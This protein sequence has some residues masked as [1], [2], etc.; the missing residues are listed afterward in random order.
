M[1]LDN[2]G[3]AALSLALQFY[4]CPGGATGHADADPVQENP[5]GAAEHALVPVQVQENPAGAAE[6]AVVPVLLQ[7]GMLNDWLLHPE[8]LDARVALSKCMEQMRLNQMW[9][10]ELEQ[11][12]IYTSCILS[13]YILI[14]IYIT[15]YKYLHIYLYCICIIYVDNRA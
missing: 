3:G 9:T 4:P 10:E 2:E 1:E 15:L 6:H 7:H 11:I 12:Y 14:F 5:A 13:I 8:L